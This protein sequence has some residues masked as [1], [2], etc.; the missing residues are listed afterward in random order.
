MSDEM[1]HFE[2]LGTVTL[3]LSVMRQM[4]HLSPID[5]GTIEF[6]DW[7][8]FV[9][10]EYKYEAEY[11][12]RETFKDIHGT[13]ITD[14]ILK[15]DVIPRIQA[16]VFKVFEH[17]KQQQDRISDLIREFDAQPSPVDLDNLDEV[18]DELHHCLEGG[19]DY[20]AVPLLRKLI[21]H[22]R[23]GKK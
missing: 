9:P 19:R 3:D 8:E 2:R 15:C 4:I 18:V 7:L 12:L 20:L 22:H 14:E 10:V 1:T 16:E 5:P 11:A 13:P 23:I 21:A 6:G 17:R